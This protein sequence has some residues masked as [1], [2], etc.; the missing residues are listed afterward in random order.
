KRRYDKEF[1]TEDG[2]SVV[3]VEITDADY[4][5][6][7]AEDCLALEN[8]LRTRLEE[9]RA[10]RRDLRL[11]SG[12]ELTGRILVPRLIEETE[13]TKR[14]QLLILPEGMEEGVAQFRMI[15]INS[16]QGFSDQIRRR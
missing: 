2:V 1:V 8:F 16:G 12:A 5:P 15:L 9:S 11:K 10:K 14:P 3:R 6:V 7:S 4:S 13:I